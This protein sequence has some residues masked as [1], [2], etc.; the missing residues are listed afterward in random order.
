MTVQY[1][2]PFSA[3]LDRAE[4]W[5][6]LVERDTNAFITGNWGRVE[7][8]FIADTFMAID[9]RMRANPDSWR[10]GF[11]SLAEYRS[12]WLEQSEAMRDLVENLEQGLYEATSMRD[13]EINADRAFAHKKFDG[14]LHRRDGGLVQLHW[15]TLYLCRRVTGTWKIA[16]FVG[17][18]PHPFSTAE[19]PTAVK[20]LPE[21]QSQPASGG[22]YSPVLTV[23]ST[24]FVVVSGQGSLGEDGS[25]VG[26]DIDEQT[27]TTI[28]N[29]ARQLEAA[30]CSLRDVF[31]VTVYLADMSEWSAFNQ[32]YR[33]AMPRPF[34][35]R[36][37]IGATLLPGLRVEI[38]MWA[39]KA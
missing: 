22:P 34:P 28:G 11:C 27:R 12:S 15:Q 2:N 5:H 26:T 32:V 25:V 16:G 35:T 31:K 29:C 19:P 23:R 8:D 10:V 30:G 18:L 24:R 4:I 9:G 7:P 21:N 20:E 6:M 38:E 13:I 33:E 39:T 17:Y 1:K 14:Q 37:T 36:T 3:D